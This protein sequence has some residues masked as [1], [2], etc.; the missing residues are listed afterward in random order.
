[1]AA[2]RAVDAGHRLPRHARVR[3]QPGEYVVELDVPDFTEED[4]VV[5]AVGPRLTIRGDQLETLDDGK[6]FR[7]HER[8]EE[9]FR[10]SDDADVDRIKVFYK[11]RTLEIHAPRTRLTPRRLPIEHRS[12]YRI[13]TD[14]AAC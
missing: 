10:L 1:M 11:H 6:A 4:L 2:M 7:L 13:N 3:E 12:P 5:E 8:F 14:A 9:T